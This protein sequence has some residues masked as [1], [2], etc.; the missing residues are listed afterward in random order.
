MAASA[1]I[2]DLRNLLAERFPHPSSATASTWT[3][4]CGRCSTRTGGVAGRSGAER[5]TKFTEAPCN[6]GRFDDV[7]PAFLFQRPTVRDAR[8]GR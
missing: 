1:K 8:R 7:G 2:I 3:R 5:F 6:E 4:S